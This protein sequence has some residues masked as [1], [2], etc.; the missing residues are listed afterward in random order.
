MLMCACKMR[1]NY[2][3]RLMLLD[4]CNANACTPTT[5]QN[6]TDRYSGVYG[7]HTTHI[8]NNNV[9]SKLTYIEIVLFFRFIKTKLIVLKSCSV[10]VLLK[11]AIKN[12][13]YFVQHRQKKSTEKIWKKKQQQQQANYHMTEL[14]KRDCS[15]LF[16]IYNI[17]P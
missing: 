10:H 16:S 5:P 7:S 15:F 1:S 12:Y 8:V 11:L 6:R 3:Y 17:H 2:N 4:E 9:S 13:D 14:P